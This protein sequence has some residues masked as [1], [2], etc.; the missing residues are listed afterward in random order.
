MIMG[1]NMATRRRWHLV[2]AV[3]AGLLATGGAVALAGTA[4][5]T[6]TLRA[7]YEVLEA[8]S[9]GYDVQYTVSNTGTVAVTGWKVEFALPAGSSVRMAKNAKLTKGAN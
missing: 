5:P 7:T 1:G 4:S 6:P 3:S 2:A 8:R 9:H